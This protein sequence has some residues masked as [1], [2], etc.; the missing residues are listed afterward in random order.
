[1]DLYLD[2]AVHHPIRGYDH[3]QSKLIDVGR[4]ESAEQAERLFP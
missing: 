3:S 1:V 4:P 2:L